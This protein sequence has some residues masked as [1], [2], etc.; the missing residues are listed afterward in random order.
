MIKELKSE[1]LLWVILCFYSTLGCACFQAN[2]SPNGLGHFLL[3]KVLPHGAVELENSDGTRF[4]VNGQRIKVYLGNA[5][6]VQ[7]VVEAYYLD[8]V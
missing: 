3:T 4:L 7:E 1:S 6:S 5:E 8:E 2:S